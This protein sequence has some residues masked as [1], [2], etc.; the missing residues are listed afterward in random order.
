VITTPRRGAGRGPWEPADQL[1]V[2][3]TSP[4]L[5]GLLL[6]GLALRLT[7]AYVLFPASGFESDLA[8]YGSWALT[9]AEHGPGGFYAN[10]GFVDYPPGYLYLLWPIGLLIRSLGEAGAS[11]GVD[12]VKLPAMLIDIAVGYVLYRLVLGWAWPG[13]RAGRL[14]LLAAALYLLNPVTMYDSALWGQTDAAGAL[15]VV[16]GVAALVRGN[17]EGATALA[18]VAALVKPQFGVVLVPIVVFILVKRHL[19]RPGSGPLHPSFGPP[20][21]AGW[22]E[23]TQG[24]ARLVTS[25]LTGLAIFHLLA[26]PFGMGLDGYLRLV[27][28]AAGGYSYLSVNAFNAWALVG[29]GGTPPLAES[30]RWSDDTLPLVGPIPAVAVGAVLLAAGFLWAL[31]RAAVRDDRW[32]LLVAAAA[33]CLFFFV[34]PTRVHERY[35]FPALAFLPLLAVVDRRWLIAFVALTIGALVN[36]HGVLTIPLYGTD[37][38][39]GLPFGEL[40]RSGPL[41]VLSAVLQTAVAA[42]AGWQLRPGVRSAPDGFDVAAAEAASHGT[43]ATPR[44]RLRSFLRAPSGRPDRSGELDGEGPGRLD[45]LD[46]LVIVLIAVSAMTLRGFRLDE[47]RAM[48]FDEVYHARTATE[49]LQHWRYGEPHDIYEYTHPHLAKYLMAAGIEVAGGNRVTDTSSLGVPVLAVALE[50]AWTSGDDPSL[51]RGDR[52]LVATGSDLRSYDLSTRE[53]EVVIDIPAHAVALDAFD[54]RLYVSDAA[55]TVSSIDTQALDAS[56][57][58]REAAPVPEPFGQLDSPGVEE[59]AVTRVSLVARAADGELAAL[60]LASGMPAGTARLPGAAGL[61][62]LPDTDRLSADPARIEDPRDAAALLADILGADPAELERRLRSRAPEVVLAAY[63]DDQARGDLGIEI[64]EGMLTG[65]VLSAGPMLAVAEETGVR[66][67]D[68]LTLDEVGAVPLAQSA[69]GLVLV[70][71]GFD[72]PRLYVAAGR[73]LWVGR[74]EDGGLLEHT[75]VPMPGPVETPLWNDAGE[76]VHVVGEAPDG[77]PAAYVI[78][79]NGHAVFADARLPGAPAS[80]VMDTR[81]DRPEVDRAQLL[82]LSPDG[83]VA[84]V[85]VGGNAFGWR[86]PGVIVGALTAACLYLLARLLFRRRSVAVLAGL[87]ALAEG[88]LFANARI[89][90]NDAYVTAFTL[91]AVTA[92]APLYL[93][94]VRRPLL[95]ALGLVA[96]GSLMGLALAAKWVALYAIAGLVLLVLLRSGLGRVIALVGMIV[97]TSVLGAMAIRPGPV[98]EP[99]QNWLF[100][101]L[102]LG[103]TAGLAAG[104]VRR[105]LRLRWPGASPAPPTGTREP[106]GWLR[107][108]RALGLPWLLALAC[109]V[110]L[111]LAVYIASYAPWVALGNQWIAGVP[112]GH[113]GQTL[114][115]LTRSMYTYHDELRA[116]HAASSPWW[117]W[118]LNLKPVW[119]YQESF[120]G[121]QTGLIHD[122][123]N[124]VILWLGIPALGFAAWAAW[125]RRSLALAMVVLLFASL[126]LPWSRID[127]ATFQYH[128]YASLPFVVLALAYLLAELWHGP[129]PRTWLLARAA[130]ALA[131]LGAPLLWLLRAP[132][133]LLAGTQSVNPSGVACGPLDRSVSVSEATFASLLVLVTAATIAAWIVWHSSRSRRPSGGRGP[134]GARSPLLALLLVAAGAFAGVASAHVLLGPGP[135]LVVSVTA[136]QAALAGFLVL[137]WPALMV[138][139]ARDPRRLVV[140]AVGAAFLWLLAWYPNLSG[141]PLPS[142]FAHL[143]Q[144]ILP[145][146]NYDFQ[147]AVNMDPAAPGGPLDATTLMVATFVIAFT[148]GIV[149]VARAE[150]P[151]EPPAEAVTEQA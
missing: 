85:A 96:V 106:P 60:D 67:L 103:L 32:T 22:L 9:L 3:A 72:Q 83:D 57:A 140:G 80:A 69:L 126:W 92:F 98:E 29:S 99:N 111:P 49:F 56:R 122:T 51:R 135:A 115:E 4:A 13:P 55:G 7:I 133:C 141:L 88:M 28:D 114:P 48:Y 151:E 86:V 36:L 76:L 53:L 71:E 91:A 93:G 19:V 58:G 65:V 47:P 50:G 113:T 116:Q 134:A 43:G 40:A 75:T 33:L 131:I 61:A 44:S 37:A 94:S 39:V 41:I 112:E 124:L 100:L 2:L 62:A 79:P 87:L 82:A 130:A 8:T 108:S 46:L 145:T 10:A 1:R 11:A 138:L 95:V 6:G 78:E 74:L 5:I 109:L 23:R 35:V 137:A 132:L 125:R 21:I 15:V 136:E 121:G 129:G 20:A 66:L 105:P 127:R 64:E 119:F 12:L 17:S 143:W 14:A 148:A 24:P 123:G 84:A 97:L 25:A 16:L 128:V 118:P 110:V 31:L 70:P 101:L 54:R 77:A 149:W 117:A 26:L 104:M 52:L 38:V 150:A 18:A 45:R 120:A 63:L 42:W 68:A 142:S 144:G 89:A 102:S 147:F 59:L 81:P 73:S 27:T 139:R 90:M 146:W 34:L 30:M 107:P